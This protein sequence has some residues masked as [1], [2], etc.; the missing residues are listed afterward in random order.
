MNNVDPYYNLPKLS[1]QY[2]DYICWKKKYINDNK[3]LE[4]Q[5]KFWNKFLL[6]NG[7][8]KI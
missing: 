6:G 4:K 3:I 7:I 5:L 2:L 8:I 1:I